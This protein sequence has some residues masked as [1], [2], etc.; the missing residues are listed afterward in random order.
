[1]INLENEFLTAELALKGAALTAK[2]RDG[3]EFMAP[4]H[5]CFPLIPLGNRVEGNGFTQD[6]QEYRFTPN[7]DEPYYIHGDGWLAE[8]QLEENTTTSARISLDQPE[9]AASPHIY[10]AEISVILEGMALH[11]RLWVSN[12]G[13]HAM[14]FGLGLH[15]FF[16]RSAGTLVTF[17]AQAFWT[18]RAG[19]LPGEREQIAPE[20]D[21]SAPNEIPQHRLNNAYE[22][23]TGTARVDWPES[24]LRMDLTA[25]P[26]FAHLMVYAPEDD[27]SFFCLEPMTHLP[28]ALAVSGPQGMHLLPPGGSLSG[29]V[30]F[31]LS[32][33][34]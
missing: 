8:W 23:W 28:N 29:V 20:N 31:R 4:G 11:V 27:Q 33:M 13:D 34:E 14:P 2:L 18:E 7:T 5:D 32:D 24:R 30:T 22:G 19:Y 6:G 15:P 17:P 1:M 3:R 12:Q 25:D 26:I 10:R 16:P 9:P 21:F